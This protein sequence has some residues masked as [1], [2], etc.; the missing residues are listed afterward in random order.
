MAQPG[1]PK[2]AATPR[3][4]APPQKAR[5]SR[6]TP[7]VLAHSS[8]PLHTSARC[9]WHKHHHPACLTS[10]GPCPGAWQHTTSKQPCTLPYLTFKCSLPQGA[11][12]GQCRLEALLNTPQACS[13]C[14]SAGTPERS[15]HCIALLESFL[16]VGPVHRIRPEKY[17]TAWSIS[18]AAGKMTGTWTHLW[19]YDPVC[20]QA[21]TQCC[22]SHLTSRCPEVLVYSSANCR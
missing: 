9:S 14:M 1:N 4:S 17:F 7:E 18:C 16:S 2:P 11:G 19:S 3:H 21:Q 6:L 22:V 13:V 10:Q 20:M 15:G 12:T 8:D 5:A